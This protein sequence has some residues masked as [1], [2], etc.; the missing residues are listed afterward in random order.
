MPA[1]AIDLT[2]FAAAVRCIVPTDIHPAARATLH[3]WLS[4]MLMAANR[5]DAAA[6]AKLAKRISDKVEQELEWERET[7]RRAI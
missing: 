5:G 3:T 7:E 2:D 6:V 4:D 1:S